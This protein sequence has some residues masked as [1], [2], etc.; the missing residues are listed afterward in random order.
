MVAR[1]VR[2]RDSSDTTETPDFGGGEEPVAP[3]PI[4][5]ADGPTEL[6]G[7]PEGGAEAAEAAEPEEA[8]DGPEEPEEAPG[9]GASRPERVYE[10]GI[11]PRRGPFPKA[12]TASGLV[13][14]YSTVARIDKA[15]EEERERIYREKAEERAKGKG[16]KGDKGSEAKGQAE[17]WLAENPNRRWRSAEALQRKKDRRA[18]GKGTGKKGEG[19]PVVEYGENLPEH[20][21]HIVDA[22]GPGGA[23][24]GSGATPTV[25]LRPS[26]HPSTE[27]ETRERSRSRDD[28]LRSEGKGSATP[29]AVAGRARRITVHPSTTRLAE[30][31]VARG[32][33]GSEAALGSN[34]R[35]RSAAA[36][37]AVAQ[38]R[39]RGTVATSIAARVYQAD[40]IDEA[41]SSCDERKTR[42]RSAVHR[43]ASSVVAK[44]QAKARARR[45]FPVA[46]K[47]RRQRPQE[48][49]NG[50]KR[51]NQR[52][53]DHHLHLK[54][55]N[56][57]LQDHR[58]RLVR[59]CII[60]AGT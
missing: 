10:L 23:S 54:R 43:F 8:G 47:P 48:H 4:V 33:I 28:P 31:R 59:G 58:L 38:A 26:D 7:A 44:S 41:C 20:L 6:E 13:Y 1:E 27:A 22:F 21:Q 60:S 17:E 55:R 35:Q 30:A 49:L 53:K 46:L 19:K 5:G 25:D 14:T 12:T 2:D 37:E 57:R 56:Q 16:A 52:R 18:K 15:E 29:K 32:A 34:Y 39:A 50:R 42:Q 36:Q 3:G 9:G 45:R 40:G 51:Q 11:V 24:S